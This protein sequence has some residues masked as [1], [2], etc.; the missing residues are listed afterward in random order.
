MLLLVVLVVGVV[1]L[2]PRESRC[3][4][5]RLRPRVVSVYDWMRAFWSAAVAVVVVVVVVGAVEG[6]AAGSAPTLRDG[7]GD[8]LR[9]NLSATALIIAV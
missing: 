4:S 8:V 2:L 7:F 3:S 5:Y 6:A 1:V 9:P